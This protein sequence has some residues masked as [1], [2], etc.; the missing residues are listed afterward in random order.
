[1]PRLHFAIEEARCTRETQRG[2]R[3]IVARLGFDSPTEVVPFGLRTVRADQHAVSAGLADSF[4]HEFVQM[5]LTV[6]PGCVAWTPRVK[7]FVW[8]MTSGI[9]NGTT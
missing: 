3:D 4:H 2:L 9:A 8:R 6:A 1:M 5:I 7:A